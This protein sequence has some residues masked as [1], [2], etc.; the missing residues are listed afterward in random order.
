[1]RLDV[2]K[3]RHGRTGMFKAKFDGDY[4]RIVEF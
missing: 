4:S 1:M 2:V 3:N